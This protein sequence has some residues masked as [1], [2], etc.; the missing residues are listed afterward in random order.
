MNKD[1]IKAHAPPG[2]RLAGTYIYKGRNGNELG[3]VA[4]FQARDG[5]KQI[6]PFTF[7]DGA[8]VGKGFPEPRPLYHLDELTARPDAK[9]LVV[10]GEKTADAAAKLFPEY[11]L[12]TSPHGAL[13]AEKAD[14]APLAGRDVTI[15]PDADEAGGKFANSV[16]RLVPGAKI[17]LLPDTIKAHAGWDLADALP[18]GVTMAD[19]ERMLASARPVPRTTSSVG[20]GK[21]PASQRMKQL[22]AE[23]KAL[24]DKYADTTG[25]VVELGDFRAPAEPV[26]PAT[27]TDVPEPAPATGIAA[28]EA[29]LEA[30]RKKMI[31]AL[32]AKGEALD[33]A[34]VLETVRS[35][36]TR[37]VAYPSEHAAVAHTLWIAHTHMMDVWDSTP[38]LHF[39]SPERGSGKTR[40]LEVTELLVP[41]PVHAVNNSVAYSIRKI[42]DETGRPTI[43]Q[44]EADV[45]IG[46]RGQPDK[47]DLIAIYNAGHR[48]GATSGRCVTGAGPVRTEELPAYCALALAGL[49]DLPDTLGSRSIIIEMRKRAP[50]ETVEP[51][52]GR[53]HRPQAKPIYE[54]L[55][56]WCASAARRIAGTYP[57][58][59]PEIIDRDADCWES[60][61]SIAN[62][63]GGTW[64]ER[65]LAAAKYLVARGTERTQTSG[66]EL[67]EHI[68]EAF[69]DEDKL[70]TKELIKRLCERDESPWADIKGHPLAD[71][72][73]AE[74]LRPY[75]IASKDVKVNGVNHKGYYREQFMDAWKR[76][77][78]TRATKATKATNLMNNSN[79]VAPV[80][81]VAPGWEK[82][83]DG[84]PFETLKDPSLPLQPKAPAK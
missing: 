75:Q 73:L 5:S 44:D 29:S 43:L 76:Y 48:K 24:A 55:E 9:V 6:R 57:E 71:R 35:F 58:L 27:P 13:S 36:L 15:W 79:L 41:R 3:I 69:A 23:A 30:L 33:G 49:R 40:A 31:D 12:V 34:T 78:Q 53:I 25:K 67:L 70:W 22:Q 63:A 11:V 47:A 72:G 62:A 32:I 28:L 54:N 26:E 45:L 80:A 14:W 38:R 39:S 77:L 82:R 20:N 46:G 83:G 51:F 8:L 65:A 17:V 60:L 61:I 52:R 10:E 84:D 19:L 21:A 2:H 1:P 74:R 4:R 16:A 7:V 64:P 68:R 18:D 81:P 50:D 56:A 66:V 42:A 37:F 59:P